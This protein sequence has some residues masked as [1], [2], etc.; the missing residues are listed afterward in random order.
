MMDPIPT[1]RFVMLLQEEIK[2][3]KIQN[4]FG[5]AG[6]NPAAVDVQHRPSAAAGDRR[7][8]LEAAVRRLAPVDLAQLDAAQ[9]HDRVESKVILHTADVPEAL[10]GLDGEYLVLEH[11]GER[12]Q[13]YRNDYFDSPELQN[14]HEHHNQKSRRLKL[15]Y[16]TYMNSDLTFFEV[17]RNVNGRTVKDRRISKRP[18]AKLCA[19]DA[20]FFFQLTGWDPTHLVPSLRV[21]YQRVLLVKHDFSERVTIDLNLA[22]T[23]EQ[24]ATQAKDLAICEFKQPKLDLRSPA[25]EAMQRRPQN[26][27]KYCMGLA[28]CDPNLRRNRFKKVFRNLDALDASLT[29]AQEV[30]A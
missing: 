29:V 13:G 15:R 3:T 12:L 6:P 14:Y 26:F 1:G 18:E 24:G 23:S 19:E 22:F 2:V 7:L 20:R 27:S 5:S 25:M 21:D 30:S 28:S 11:E 10:S 8:A 17:K 16:R 9:L 4:G